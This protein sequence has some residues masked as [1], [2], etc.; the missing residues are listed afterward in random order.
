MLLVLF[1]DELKLKS[2]YGITHVNPDH[3]FDHPVLF[4]CPF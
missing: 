2:R 4:I 3:L 1:Q